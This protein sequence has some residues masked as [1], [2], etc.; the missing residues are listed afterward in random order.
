MDINIINEDPH[1][2][3]C[4]KP[5]GVPSQGDPTGDK[6]ML[7]LMQEHIKKQHPNVK[8][9]YVGLVHRLDR[10]VG[11]AM[12]FAKVKEANAFL[13]K[14]M[15]DKTFQKK[16]LVVVC[17]KPQAQEGELRDY[18][19]KLASVNMSKVVHKNQKNAK[20]AILQY[21]LLS[22]ITDEEHGVLSLLEIQLKTGRHHQI[23]VQLSNQGLGIWGDNKYNESFVKNKQWTQIAL[24]S[25]ELSFIHPKTKK[26]QTYNSIPKDIYPFSLFTVN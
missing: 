23:R 6:D 4:E 16:Y 14:Q 9:P 3:I 22:S 21:K 26:R 5:P 25:Q 2:I 20:E 19:L 8:N 1:I 17:G 18:L 12:I 11:G 7:T 24:W 15:Q 13:S 10:P